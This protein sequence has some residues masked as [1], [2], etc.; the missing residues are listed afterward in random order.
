MRTGTLFSDAT[1]D[2]RTRQELSWNDAKLY[3]RNGIFISHQQRD[4]VKAV[5][6]G[7]AIFTAT[8]VPCYVDALDPD[9]KG[10][11]ADLVTY[12]QEVIHQCRSL[13]AVVS[14]NTRNSW[15]VP[16][17]I[18]VG[19]ESRKYIG[20]YKADHIELPSY[21]WAWP[22][23]K[24]DN[25]AIEWVCATIRVGCPDYLHDAWRE[26]NPKQYHDRTTLFRNL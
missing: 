16:L 3:M 5:K 18:G 2:D 22:T 26:S 19:L 20:T 6:V 12:I 24:N 17:E 7:H 13:L 10:D 23:M 25:E 9:L 8:Q 4:T 15:W 21:L 14:T 11:S 1:L